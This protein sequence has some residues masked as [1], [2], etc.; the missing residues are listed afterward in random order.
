VSIT[1]QVNPLPLINVS[2]SAP[3][4]CLGETATLTATGAQSFNWNPGGT[5]VTIPVSPSVT[6]N[7]TVT[8]TDNFGCINTF[9]F[10]QVV[11]LCTG[12]ASNEKISVI[13]VYPNPNGGI[14]TV[15]INAFQK[16]LMIKIYNASGQLVHWEVLTTSTNVINTPLK[17]G[18][19]FYLLGN[20]G[21]ALKKGKIVVE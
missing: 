14:F 17:P 12:L 7:Y 2:S 6:T 19:Y 9:T 15:N 11:D 1:V 16:D 3:V 13:S 20:D 8:G 10:N 5:G 4:L 18:I 21:G